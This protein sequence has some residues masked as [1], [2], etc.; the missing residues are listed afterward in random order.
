[1]FQHAINIFISHSWHHSGDYDTLQSWI[2]ERPWIMHNPGSTMSQILLRFHD[3]SIPKED[4]IHVSDNIYLLENAISTKIFS[5]HVVVIPM[6]MYA[7]YS[8]WIKREINIASFYQKPKLAVNIQGQDRSPSIVRENADEQARWNR[9][10]VVEKIW[11]LC[12]RSPWQ[13][14]NR[15]LS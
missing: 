7:R 9:K 5:S 2:F 6:G 11:Q 13:L 1:M 3:N 14:K 4:P 12:N 8:K 15:L 10:S